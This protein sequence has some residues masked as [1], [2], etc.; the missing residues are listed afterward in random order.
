M[1][2]TPDLSYLDA[3]EH[4]GKEYDHIRK[5]LKLYAK[6]IEASNTSHLREPTV[7]K[8]KYPLGDDYT[9][10]YDDFLSE[11]FLRLL[12]HINE[13]F[14]NTSEVFNY[15]DPLY[16]KAQSE[17]LK[18][19][20]GVGADGLPWFRNNSD[21]VE[22]GLEYCQR[23][24]TLPPELLEPIIAIA[25]VRDMLAARKLHVSVVHKKI[26]VRGKKV[27]PWMAFCSKY[28]YLILGA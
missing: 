20:H 18:L 6:V 12:H 9:F 1:T 17:M 2:T 13:T 21:R 26:I 15:S 28:S 10:S 24:W 3:P 25:I 19:F 4:I 27:S 5:A 11:K 16:E 23:L 7:S 14:H 8:R 22:T